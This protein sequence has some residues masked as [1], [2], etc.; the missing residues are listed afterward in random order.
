M[1]IVLIC[2]FGLGR[3]GIFLV[4]ISHPQIWQVFLFFWSCFRLSA[5]GKGFPHQ[6]LVTR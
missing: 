4:L 2:K 6:D 3:I 1:G 5:K